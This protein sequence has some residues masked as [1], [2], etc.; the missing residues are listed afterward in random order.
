MSKWLTGEAGVNAY[1]QWNREKF[2]GE[3]IDAVDDAIME[4]LEMG[5]FEFSPQEGKVGLVD[6]GVGGLCEGNA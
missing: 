6:R 3:E 1:I 5:A 2:P 4:G